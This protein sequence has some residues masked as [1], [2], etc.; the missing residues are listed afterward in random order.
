MTRRVVV[1]SACYAGTWIPALA[2]DNTIV[3]TASAKDRKSFGCDDSRRLTVF[4]EAFLG[5]LAQRDVPLADAFEAAKRQIAASEREQELDPSLPQAYVG[6]NMRSLWSGGIEL[7]AVKRDR[8][9]ASQ[10]SRSEG[11]VR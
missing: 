8:L 10:A 4:G 6:R 3:I 2:D 11:A 7:S 1:V 9:A 5:R